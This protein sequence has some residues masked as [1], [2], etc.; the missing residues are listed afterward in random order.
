MF[1]SHLRWFKPQVCS[2]AT[3]I[4]FSLTVLAR[5]T[6]I[7]AIWRFLIPHW[8]RGAYNTFSTFEWDIFS[9]LEMPAF[10]TSSLYLILSI[11]LGLAAVWFGTRLGRVFS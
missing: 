8:F 3:V 4:G 10:L 11:V 6:E 9:K 7:D 1:L 2:T 5:R